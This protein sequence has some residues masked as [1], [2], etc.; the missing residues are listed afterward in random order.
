MRYDEIFVMGGDERM[1][2]VL[3]AVLAVVFGVALAMI[4]VG[5]FP[6]PGFF[7]GSDES[8]P[9]YPKNVTD[10]SGRNITIYRPLER[11]VVLNSDVAE[12]I[13]L[14][15]AE[16]R[17]VGVSEELK[18]KKAFFPVISGKPSVGKWNEPNT[19]RILELNADA[20]F[21]Y[22]R[23]PGEEKLED[24]L[25]S[26]VNVIRFDFY[27]AKTLRDELQKLAVL[28][29]EEENASIY[30]EWHDKIMG[31]ISSKLKDLKHRTKVFI[32]LKGTENERKT[33][34]K[35]TGMDELCEMAGGSNIAADLNAS[36]P[37]VSVEWILRVD[38]DAIIHL[39]YKGGYEKSDASVLK[40]EYD[41]VKR[42]LS[43][44]KAARENRIHVIS[45]DVAFAPS[46]P[47]GMAYISKW[48]NP[49]LFENMDPQA[50]HQEY[51]NRF[52]RIKFNVSEKG[53]FVYP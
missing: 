4:Y 7:T 38:P 39:S 43:L 31:E 9:G 22:V 2:V 20:V 12:A 19:E 21:T 48:I 47:V 33:C 26:S 28:L 27:K 10:S 29:G 8:H 41:E 36:Y 37:S 51:I 52:C 40:A 5:G 14:L 44:T 32:D 35:G 17:I 42:V 13:R 3:A 45:S 1:R 34:A 25:P 53:A 50:I 23:W 15:G 16:D 49:E 18:K 24:K 30:L 11:I 46:Y 6:Q